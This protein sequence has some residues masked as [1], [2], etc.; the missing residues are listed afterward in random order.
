MQFY[1][2]EGPDY[3]LGA[4]RVFLREKLERQLEV[5][6]AESLKGAAVLIQKNIRGYL[7]RKKYR[8]MRRSAITVQKYWKGY[9]Q[10]NRFQKVRKGVV[11]AQALVRGRIERKRFAKRKAEFRRRVEAEKVAKERARQRAEREA[12][13][14]AQAKKS[15][16]KAAIAKPNGI[17]QLD[18]P[19]ELSLIFSKLD[20]Y[21]PPH[22]EKNMMKVLGGVTGTPPPLTLPQDIH[23]FEFSKFSS[24]YFKGNIINFFRP[25]KLKSQLIETNLIIFK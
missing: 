20:S 14:Q 24:V 10:R 25:K 8:R 6:R 9:K 1:I 13:L 18:I 17:Q 3:Q 15:A 2:T 12:Q 5:K 16:A 23:Q 19:P 21:N 22:T 7:A 4:S 11:K